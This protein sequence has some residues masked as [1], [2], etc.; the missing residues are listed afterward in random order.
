MNVTTDTVLGQLQEENI[1]WFEGKR[2]LVTGGAG[3]IGS[4]LVEALV[5]L[6]ARVYVADNLWRGSLDNLM[7][8]SG[9]PC[10]DLN[11][12]FIYADLREYHSCL[13]AAMKADLVYHLADIVA[14]ID[15]VFGN[16]PLLYR[17]NILINSNMITAAKEVGVQTF[18]YV[19]AACSYPKELQARPG[20][21]PLHE[22]QAY[23]ANP[24]SGYGWSKLMGE[25]ETQ[26]M[27]RNSS[28]QVGILRLH[29]VYGPRSEFAVKRSQV[30]PSLIRKAIRYPDEEFRVW[31]SGKQTRSFVY[32]ADIVDALLR[33]PYCGLGQGAIQIG[34]SEQT[35]IAEL[36]EKIIRISGKSIPLVFD[37]T[38]PEGDGG[39]SANWEKARK[40]LGWSPRVSMDEGL[41]Q[42]YRWI[43]DQIQ[44]KH[45]ETDPITTG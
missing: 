28:T 33:V 8:E 17:S 23:P 3:F 32:I 20:G 38:K 2:C 25:Y 44:D 40:V 16:E 27:G 30:I 36:A 31:G 7:D 37:T 14:G 21:E 1:R 18:V 12:R 15:F 42:T 34:T 22:D 35:A 6:G 39:R 43:Y 9:K 11:E 41:E 10:V 24:E 4:W 13:V 29:N 26:L 19:G 5:R 45:R